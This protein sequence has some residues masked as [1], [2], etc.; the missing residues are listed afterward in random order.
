MSCS[1]RC[2]RGRPQPPLSPRHA[3]RRG[4][5]EI[6]SMFGIGANVG[7]A[8]SG[9][10]GRGRGSVGTGGSECGVVA[11][12]LRQHRHVCDLG[13][14]KGNHVGGV[15]VARLNVVQPL[16]PV[17][18]RDVVA[19]R[20]EQPLQHDLGLHRRHLQRAHHFALREVRRVRTHGVDRVETRNRPLL[21]V[22]R[23]RPRVPALTGSRLPVHV[24]DGRD[25][26][27]RG[28]VVGRRRL[29]QLGVRRLERRVQPAPTPV[30]RHHGRGLLH[31]RR[32]LRRRLRQVHGRLRVA[33]VAQV[34][35]GRRERLAL[36]EE[37]QALLRPRQH[38]HRVRAAALH[39]LEPLDEV[40]GLHVPVARAAELLRVLRLHVTEH[41]LDLRLRHRRLRGLRG[42]EDAFEDLAC[43][44]VRVLVEEAVL[45]AREA[46][47][48]RLLHHRQLLLQPLE[49]VL[50]RLATLQVAEPAQPLVEVDFARVIGVQLVEEH[51]C[52]ECLLAQHLA[53]LVLRHV[54]V[55]LAQL[56]N[57]VENGGGAVRQLVVQHALVRVLARPEHVDLL[58]QPVDLHLGRR[59]RQLAAR[60]PDEVDGAPRGSELGAAALPL[61]R[62][63]PLRHV[64]EADATAPAQ[65]VGLGSGAGGGVAAH[66]ARS[67]VA[68]LLRAVVQRELQLPVGHIRVVVR[69]ATNRI[70]RRDRLVDAVLGVRRRLGHRRAAGAGRPLRLPVRG[71]RQPLGRGGRLG[72]APLLGGAAGPGLDGR[73]GR[74][75]GVGVLVGRRRVLRA[76]GTVAGRAGRPLLTRVCLHRL[77]VRRSRRGPP[78]VARG[79]R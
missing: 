23:Q 71:R 60:L 65:R 49:H 77:L 12:C 67:R 24:V 61:Q 17:S 52:A 10:Y 63:L 2:L 9:F 39:V 29:V 43:L 1:H 25:V 62:L 30:A 55:L 69:R 76:C 14:H 78:P 20:L 50:R 18:H 3:K 4:D 68:G 56:V 22:L 19:S 41:V 40:R 75:T 51:L 48:L 79:R 6:L 7:K 70:N 38:L 46:D 74:E 31:G 26:R 11:F 47:L 57:G 28:E 16:D 72:R 59:R 45:V 66:L 33:G 58:L 37:V 8:M 42:V 54:A 13:L 53:Q 27:K 5:W 44:G 21:Q 64:D 35:G 36:V 15:P 73:A 32:R 34:A